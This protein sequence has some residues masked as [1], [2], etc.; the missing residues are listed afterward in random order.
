MY[1]CGENCP[2]RTFKKFREYYG[3]F[4][5]ADKWVE[6]AFDSES[7]SFDRANASFNRYGYKARAEAI[8]KAIVYMSVWMYVIREMESALDSCKDDCKK[9]GCN[10]EQVRA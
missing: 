10:D 8:K 6:A 1:R 9:T 3:F 4:D 7:T 2:Y 5:Y